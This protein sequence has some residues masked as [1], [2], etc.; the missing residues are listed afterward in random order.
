VVTE[1]PPQFG[2]LDD[3]KILVG[4]NSVGFFS[5]KLPA[6]YPWPPPPNNNITPTTADWFQ[7]HSSFEAIP[8]GWTPAL[9]V[10][11][12]ALYKDFL[13]ELIV[14]GFGQL[15]IRKEIIPLAAWFIRDMSQAPRV[16]LDPYYTV[17]AGS[18]PPKVVRIG[19]Q[20]GPNIWATASNVVY[21]PNL[22]DSKDNP[23]FKSRVQSVAPAYASFILRPYIYYPADEIPHTDTTIV[24]QLAAIYGF[25]YDFL[26]GVY[27][28]DYPTD[29]YATGYAYYDLNTYDYDRPDPYGLYT[30]EDQIAPGTTYPLA[31]YSSELGSG[32]AT[33]APE[34][35]DSAPNEYTPPAWES[36]RT[37][38]FQF[39][40]TK[41]E[42]ETLVKNLANNA[43]MGFTPDFFTPKL[44]VV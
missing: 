14:E 20:Y 1:A 12:P 19:G 37:D 40:A 31:D 5:R 27:S 36:A 38:W 39:V 16:P 25:S 43:L 29:P 21:H 2:V 28:E 30:N 26:T 24:A 17:S 10:T 35:V 33:Y 8:A 3:T 18:T 13:Y 11:S 4:L 7:M 34:N 44:G 23:V 32:L 15:V 6:D 9:A 41:T 42:W 22:P